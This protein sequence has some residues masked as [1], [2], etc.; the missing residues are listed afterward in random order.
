MLHKKIST[1]EDVNKLS[2]PARLLFTWMIAHADDEGRLKGEPSF[3]KVAVVP[4][5]NW[6]KKL[7]EQ[8][9]NQM[10]DVGLIYYW[11]KNNQ[12]FI[13]FPKWN[14]YQSIRKDRFEPS[15]LP[16]FSDKNDNQVSTNSQPEVNQT[17]HQANISEVNKRESNIS[18]IKEV[19]DKKSFTDIGE[20]IHPKRFIPSNPGESEALR[21]WKRLEPNN[22]LAFT[23]TY[24]WAYKKGLSSGKFGVFASEIEQDLTVKNK[25]AVFLSKVK[26]YLKL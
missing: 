6:S 24:L 15:K 11:K 20:L 8:Y 12:R 16:S 13:E 4:Y 9:L 1:S 17:T 10:K 3:I 21:T 26:A 23:T 19:A 22:P 25:G 5:T 14:E 18:E 7:I 2:L